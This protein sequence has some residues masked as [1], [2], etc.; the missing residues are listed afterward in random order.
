MRVILS[1][2]GNPI[3]RTIRWITRGPWSHASLLRPDNMV[4]EA[5]WPRVRL[6]P[7]AVWVKPMKPSNFQIFTVET[8]APQSE[9]VCAYA[10]AQVG[11]PYDLIGDLHFLTRQGYAD[12]PDTKWF[13]SELVFESFRE[14]GIHLFARTEGWQVDPQLLARS[15]LVE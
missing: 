4:L 1:R 2:G 6:L 8:T 12:Q 3:S 10:L 14:A 15:T 13:C 11:K 9:D 5:V 7:F